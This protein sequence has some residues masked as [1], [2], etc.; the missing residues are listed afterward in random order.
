MEPEDRRVTEREELERETAGGVQQVW[1]ILAAV[2]AVGA[3]SALLFLAVPPIWAAL[4]LVLLA[5][6]IGGTVLATGIQ[7]PR[8]RL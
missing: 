5:L 3:V 2:A 1:S 8:H 7:R 4:A 6:L